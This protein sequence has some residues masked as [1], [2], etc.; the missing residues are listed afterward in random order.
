[1]LGCA[2]MTCPCFTVIW[3]NA[4]LNVFWTFLVHL[5]I[6]TGAYLLFHDMYIVV[7][8]LMLGILGTTQ[9]MPATFLL[10]FL[11]ITAHR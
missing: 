2:Y 7:T 3:N 8:N 6:E 10:I 5:N 4:Y 1:M 11:I 9:H